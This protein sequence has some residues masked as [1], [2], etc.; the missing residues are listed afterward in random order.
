[1][2]PA[3]MASLM[4]RLF[5]IQRVDGPVNLAP[6]PV[7]TCFYCCPIR[8]HRDIEFQLYTRRNPKRA[9]V[10][11]ITNPH[12]LR[13]SKFNRDKP[14]VLYIHGYSEKAPGRSSATIRDVYLKRGDYNL[15]LV[16]WGKLAALPWYVTAVR[17]T[18]IVG[19]YVAR[20]VSWLDAKGAVP[21]SRIHVI[22]FSLGAEVAGFMGKALAPR[23]I[24]R[25]TGLD[26]AYPLYMN[27]GMEGHLAATDAR[28]VD[29]IHTDGGRFGFPFPLG[30][31]DFYPNGGV[32]V[33]PGCNLES[34]IRRSISR[35]INQYITCGHN[36]AWMFYAESVKNPRGFAASRC[37]RWRPNIRANCLW[38]PDALMGFA[39]D[40]R[41]T[42]MYYLR[43][44]A[45]PPYATNATG[46]LGK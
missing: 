35:L 25:I 14:T 33:Q 4:C 45:E 8:L 23:K 18:R 24:G 9:D 41:T 44:N 16:N 37:P 1:M 15:I 27:T 34:I 32:R 3:F 26:P 6:L 7:G 5:V 20:F 29:I 10:L 43:T 30:H 28:F 19:P 22:G 31:V 42:G 2:L 12:S 13:M 46:Y 36:R 39:V 21:L 40:S 11:N 38:S 17:N